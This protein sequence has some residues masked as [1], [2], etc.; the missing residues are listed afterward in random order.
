MDYTS[1]DALQIMKEA[2]QRGDMITVNALVRTSE[3]MNRKTTS[4]NIERWL[5][6]AKP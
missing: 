4:S 6:D 5:K 3:F 2:I 1:A